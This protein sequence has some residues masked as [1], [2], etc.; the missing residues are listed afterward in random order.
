MA[1]LF[2]STYNVLH[3]IVGRLRLAL[4][5]D[6]VDIILAAVLY[7]SADTG[8]AFVFV[9]EL[10]A[11]ILVFRG[12]F[13][14]DCKN[15]RVVDPDGFRYGRL[16]VCLFLAVL[17]VVNG[18][19]ELLCLAGV[20][21]IVDVQDILARGNGQLFLIRADK[22]VAANFYFFVL[23]LDDIPK[24]PAVSDF[25]MSHGFVGVHIQVVHRIGVVRADVAGV[26][27]LILAYR[28]GEGNGR[29]GKALVVVPAG[30][31]ASMAVDRLRFRAV[32]FVAGNGGPRVCRNAALAD[33]IA[34]LRKV[35]S[36][37]APEQ[38]LH[39][40]DVLADHRYRAVNVMVRVCAVMPGHLVG[41]DHNAQNIAVLDLVAV[42]ALQRCPVGIRDHPG[43]G[44]QL[45]ALGASLEDGQVRAGD[46]AE[47]RRILS[48]VSAAPHRIRHI[49]GA[50]AVMA[51]PLR[52]VVGH[53][54]GEG[55]HQVIELRLMHIIPC[56]EDRVIGSAV[57]RRHDLGTVFHIGPA[58]EHRV[59]IQ[60]QEG[61]GI[62]QIGI[63]D[64]QLIAAP[65]GLGLSGAVAGLMEGRVRPRRQQGVIGPAI[66]GGNKALAV[67]RIGPAA[68][69]RV[70]LPIVLDLRFRITQVPGADGGI[71]LTLEGLWLCTLASAQVEAG[72]YQLCQHGVVGFPIDRGNSLR[73]VRHI[74]PALEHI[75][76]GV[77]RKGVL[78]SL[79][80]LLLYILA[81]L[82][83]DRQCGL[84]ALAVLIE[85]SN[86][87]EGIQL[88]VSPDI[89]GA[90]GGRSLCG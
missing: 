32:R 5:L 53:R 41:H 35:R 55:V 20:L 2:P 62:V 1:V 65:E 6:I 75:I 7:G 48:V 22:G 69:R 42:R 88:G 44:V 37:F 43:V 79:Q 11:G 31:G 23:R 26:I 28:L 17:I 64:S 8:E 58:A 78:R 71:F 40:D 84:G 19:F 60:C 59:G 36:G 29:T 13:A 45:I 4:V 30:K 18:V 27:S 74:G 76:L 66:D 49:H 77:H 24:L 73:A 33:H 16:V 25:C 12:D 86:R 70:E 9:G 47:R 34:D 14:C 80:A 83:P 82:A 63:A 39:I 56:A 52:S 61:L 72:F 15:I 10:I 87:A 81:G 54:M 85:G 67:R 90:K 57:D 3:S 89:D 21:L 68:E 38:E 51:A 46:N 50:V